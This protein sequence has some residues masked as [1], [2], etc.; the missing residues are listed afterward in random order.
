[1]SG[2]SP[3]PGPGAGQNCLTSLETLPPARKDERPGSLWGLCLVSPRCLAPMR[4]PT[5]ISAPTPSLCARRPGPSFWNSGTPTPLVHS[6]GP[7]RFCGFS[8]SQDG[9]LLCRR[10]E[11][12]SCLPEPQRAVS[13]SR[14]LTGGAGSR[15]ALVGTAPPP[16]SAR[17]CPSLSTCSLAFRGR[18]TT[19][20]L[21]ENLPF[22]LLPRSE[23]QKHLDRPTHRG[24][25]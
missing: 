12:P 15:L 17:A 24:R 25:V 18:T 9:P 2:D 3:A 11:A 16:P 5:G 4:S 21:P 22:W 23:P 10:D 19:Y 13:P 20:S 6:P 7:R 1:M 8:P 14:S